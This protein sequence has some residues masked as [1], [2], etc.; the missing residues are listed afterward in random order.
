MQYIVLAE[1]H[2]NHDLELI[3][4]N[5]LL[6]STSWDITTKWSTIIHLTSLLKMFSSSILIIPLGPVTEAPYFATCIPLPAP[7]S[8]TCT[9]SF[10]P[11]HFNLITSAEPLALYSSLEDF[12]NFLCKR[13]RFSSGSFVCGSSRCELASS[14]A[15]LRYRALTALGIN[16][17]WNKE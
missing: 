9:Y 16:S 3:P 14:W 5:S 13:Y 1:Y 6:F 4:V 7:I 12:S 10:T 2:L 8:S 11:Q 17:P 15:V